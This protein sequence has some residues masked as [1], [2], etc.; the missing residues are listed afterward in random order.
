MSNIEL[1]GFAYLSKITR[2]VRLS[3]LHL[4][5]NNLCEKAKALLA[6]DKK[7]LAIVNAHKAKYQGA[8]HAIEL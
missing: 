6:K 5:D 3:V 7:A 8:Y 1:T 2:E 4:F